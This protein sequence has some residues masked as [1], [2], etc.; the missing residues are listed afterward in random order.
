[1]IHAEKSCMKL[2]PG[3]GINGFGEDTVNVAHMLGS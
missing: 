3:P 2:L 1:M